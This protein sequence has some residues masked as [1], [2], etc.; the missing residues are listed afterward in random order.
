M[1]VA[2][3]FVFVFCKKHERSLLVCL[4]FV[5]NMNVACWFVFFLL[6]KHERSLLVCLAST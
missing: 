1:N 6:K 3:W 2:C 4:F 5:K